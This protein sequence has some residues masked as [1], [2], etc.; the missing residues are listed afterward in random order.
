MVTNPASLSFPGVNGE[1]GEVCIE[2]I[3]PCDADCSSKCTSKH[4]GGEGYCSAVNKVF[5]CRCYYKCG[6]PPPSSPSPPQLAPPPT[7]KTCSV[8]TTRC[9][10]ACDENC[11]ND[12]C[13]AK[14]PGPKEGY[15]KCVNTGGPPS[16]ILCTCYFKC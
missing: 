10:V 14:Y 16:Y 12:D 9:S 15:G 8:G 11:C 4:A 5:T 13:A 2:N 6:V 3:G 7:T 1:G